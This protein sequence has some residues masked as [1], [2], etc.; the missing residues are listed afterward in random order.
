MGKIKILLLLIIP[1]IPISVFAICNANIEI[2]SNIEVSKIPDPISFS[3]DS[4]DVIAN[5][6]RTNNTSV[7][8]IG[9]TKSIDMGSFGTH[10]LRIANKSTPSE[11]STSGFSQTACV[12][13]TFNFT[14]VYGSCD[15]RDAYNTY[16]VSPAFR[17]G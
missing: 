5:A 11:C 3:T 17:I 7:Y 13:C 1:F 2:N 16:G 6:V 9:D 14:G 12:S 8:N 10:T 4:W 15:N